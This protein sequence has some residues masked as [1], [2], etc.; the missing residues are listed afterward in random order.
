MK[1]FYLILLI[2]YGTQISAHD[3]CTSTTCQNGGFCAGGDGHHGHLICACPAGFTGTNCEEIINNCDPVP[4]LNGGACLTVGDS[5]TCGCPP[6]YG[7]INCESCQPG[8][9]GSGCLA[10]PLG[11]GGLNC[12]TDTDKCSPDPCQNEGACLTAGDL[13][14]GYSYT[15]AC[16]PDHG[17]L[18]CEFEIITCDTITCQN[19]FDCS[20]TLNT[21]GVTEPICNCDVLHGGAFCEIEINKCDPDPCQ[22][23]A[24]CV[25]DIQEGIAAF[26]CNCP[27]N[28]IGVNCETNS[29]AWW[30]N[31][32]ALEILFLILFIILVLVV[33][34]Y[35]STMTTTSTMA[36]AVGMVVNVV[37]DEEVNDE[38]R[39]LIETSNRLNF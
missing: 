23:G 32:E 33:F 10:C 3:I 31:L 2:A 28:F 1:H 8:Y 22:N 15:C 6:G 12:E 39:Q 9:G 30:N 35:F 16:P 13:T 24:T 18:N 19:N 36:P 7:G 25:T 14:A 4:C 21:S 5:Y 26:H 38:E 37:N 17:G 11:Y 29:S 27:S 34:C 20:D